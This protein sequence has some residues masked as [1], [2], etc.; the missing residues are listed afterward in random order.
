MAERIRH[1]VTDLF[2]W[3]R[4][5]MC[6]SRPEHAGLSKLALIC[7]AERAPRLVQIRQGLEKLWQRY[8]PYADKNFVSEFGR[9]PEERFWEMYLGGR[10]L[11][12][13]KALRKR[14]Q[15]S[16]A[17]R[18]EGPDF[19]IQKGRRR[20]WIE[21]IAPSPGNEENLDKV[22]HLFASGAQEDAR[23]QIELR[24]AS[25]LKAKA[26]KFARYKEKGRIDDKDS[27]IIAIS[28]SQFALEAAGDGLPHPVTTVYPFGEEV[29]TIDPETSEFASL[30]HKYSG[31]IE[32]IKKDG[33]KPEAI[34]RTAFQN[35]YFAGIDGLI[36]SRRSTGNF[37][38]NTD[39]LVFVHNQL[40]KR[41]LPKS[42][43]DWTEEY[44]PVDE[45][46]KLRRRK[47]PK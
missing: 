15:L 24:I 36:W 25:A 33:K 40:A 30:G 32:R 13:R 39:D 43:L 44:F 45:G 20:I 23:R 3:D 34:P 17:G 18:D 10:L 28:A 5:I 2:G 12:G 41:P 35:G 22:P 38:G 27:C 7:S 42:W 4:E 16:K 26:D 46:K 9:H 47:R 37:L 14:K 19:C 6:V 8:E 11:D 29:I 1:L 21:V 31:E